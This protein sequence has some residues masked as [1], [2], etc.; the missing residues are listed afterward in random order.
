MNTQQQRRDAAE[1]ALVAE[2]LGRVEVTTAY[3]SHANDVRRAFRI[4]LISTGEALLVREF[5]ITLG[6][7]GT[8]EVKEQF[9]GAADQQ[10][11]GYDGLGIA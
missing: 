2:G 11:G 7:K 4:K 6:P 1:I 10:R 5:V 3:A 9:D 8:F